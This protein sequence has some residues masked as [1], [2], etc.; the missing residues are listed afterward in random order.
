[1][2]KS[3]ILQKD[4]T[5]NQNGYQ[6]KLP[7][8]IDCIIPKDDSVRLLSQFVEEMDLSDLYSTY[9]RI[10]ENPSPR[11]ILKVVPYAYMNGDFSSRDME[12]DCRRDI[13]FMLL[14]EG[15]PRLTMRLLPA[16]IPCI[17][18]RV[19]KRFWPPSQSSFTGL[20]KFQEKTSLLTEQR[21]RLMRINTLLSGKRR[22]QKTWK[23]F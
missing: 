6:L 10:P 15:A 3:N 2:E 22:Q 4:Y 5:L 17:S 7:L 20:G 16:S 11:T 14:L 9:Q 1:M 21:S 18:Y 13:N 8:N 12:K 19:Q 23:N